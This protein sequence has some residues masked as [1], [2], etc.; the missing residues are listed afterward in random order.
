M[1]FYIFLIFFIITINIQKIQTR[2]YWQFHNCRGQHCDALESKCAQQTTECMITLIDQFDCI[3]EKQSC[4]I[5]E[6]QSFGDCWKECKQKTNN[7]Y[8]KEMVL[9]Y[10][11]CGAAENS[12]IIMFNF[13]SLLIFLFLSFN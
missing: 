13:L 11:D 4:Q 6:G 5:E 10:E 1:K 7:D 8:Y 9:C 12:Q 2:P 3:S